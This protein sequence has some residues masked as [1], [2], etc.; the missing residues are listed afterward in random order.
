MI[1]NLDVEFKELDR[2]K[3]TLP[4][5]TA[6]EVAAFANTAGG[7]MY[8]GIRDDGSVAGINDPDDVMTRLSNTIR[9]STL[10]DV[11]PF[12]QIRCVEMEGKHVV[13]ATVSIGTERPYYLAREGLRPKGVYGL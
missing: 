12:V 6:K 11:M 7:T 8:I 4:D 1:E 3:G 13:Q 5:S 9:D 10:P 2:F